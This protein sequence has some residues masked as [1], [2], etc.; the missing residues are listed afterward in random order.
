MSLRVFHIV[1]VV[2]AAVLS[3]YVSAWGFREFN[4]SQ[5][6]TGFVLGVLFLATTVALA[7]YGPK[8]FRKLK[9]LP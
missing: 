1:F 8:V 9:E 3:V 7:I 5:S 6:A 2:V 4:R